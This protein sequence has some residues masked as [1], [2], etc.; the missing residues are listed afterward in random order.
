MELKNYYPLV[1]NYS[2][3]GIFRSR[4]IFSIGARSPERVPGTINFTR[5][6]IQNGL[7]AQYVN[8]Q[9][10]RQSQILGLPKTLIDFFALDF[11]QDKA[12]LS[13]EFRTIPFYTSK[14]NRSS[15]I[16]AKMFAKAS[17]NNFCQESNL[18]IIFSRRWLLENV[19]VDHQDLHGLFNTEKPLN[20]AIDM[21]NTFKEQNHKFD[22]ASSRK[23]L[24]KAAVM[25]HVDLFFERMNT[26]I[27]FKK[28]P[29]RNIHS[30]DRQKLMFIK[31]K[32]AAHP[33][34]RISVS[35][36]ADISA[37]SVSKFKRLFKFYFDTT[38]Y[39]YQ[40]RIRMEKAMKI[41]K[42]GCYSVSETGYR[43]GYSNPSQ[44]SKA[45]KNHFGILPSQ[46]NV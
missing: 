3:N 39:R 36:L 14:D 25:Q 10:F 37:M 46:V 11:F 42:Q 34:F 5:L 20:I 23:L 1:S 43:M 31:K 22:F 41:L 13:Q 27:Y 18:S 8:N 29:I 16:S 6:E 33:E 7:S 19:L 44:F 35:D 12:F 30:K 9:I 38:P 28:N 17:V 15:M 21:D 40:L 2:E 4:T 26:S 45:F 24:A 32:I